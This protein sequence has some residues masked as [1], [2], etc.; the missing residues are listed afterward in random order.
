MEVDDNEE[1][2]I[3]KPNEKKER[4]LIAWSALHAKEELIVRVI[5]SGFYNHMI[6][7]TRKFINIEENEW[8]ISEVWWCGIDSIL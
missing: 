1:T 3:Q 4:S 2:Y 5:D 7:D 8:W 6:G